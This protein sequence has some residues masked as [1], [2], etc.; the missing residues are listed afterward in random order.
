LLLDSCLMQMVAVHQVGLHIYNWSKVEFSSI[1]VLVLLS[2]RGR[3][4]TQID[5]SNFLP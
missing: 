4:L 1:A 2:K 3:S 5:E